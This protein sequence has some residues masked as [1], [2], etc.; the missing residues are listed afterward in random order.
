MDP[1]INDTRDTQQLDAWT[2]KFNAYR[3]VPLIAGSAIYWLT[4]AMIGKTDPRMLLAPID[5][6]LRS[7]AGPWFLCLGI[8]AC[9]TPFAI[10]ITLVAPMFVTFAR[11]TTRYLLILAGFIAI[12]GVS[13]FLMTV[14]AMV[15]GRL[16][17]WPLLFWHLGMILVA[18]GCVTSPATANIFRNVMQCQACGYPLRPSIEAGSTACPECGEPIDVTAY[19]ALDNL[20]ARERAEAIRT[21]RLSSP[22]TDLPPPPPPTDH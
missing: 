15:M 7:T 14:V 8:P 11:L 22:P 21:G 2:K 1:D 20:R 4:T 18:V 19:R 10:I 9:L 16:E 6:A 17:L 3:H 5:L 13:N 12:V